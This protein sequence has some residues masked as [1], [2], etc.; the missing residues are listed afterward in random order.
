M[1]ATTNREL[2]D[3]ARKETRIS[4]FLTPFG[5]RE[6]A[7]MTIEEIRDVFGWTAGEFWSAVRC[8]RIRI[9]K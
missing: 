4:A 6:A 2:I 8:G 3:A 9:A 1:M 7:E 5:I